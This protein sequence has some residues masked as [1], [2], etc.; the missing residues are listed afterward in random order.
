MGRKMI[1][2]PAWALVLLLAGVARADLG[3]LVDRLPAHANAIVAVDVAPLLAARQAGGDVPRSPVPLPRVA[4]LQGLVLAAHVKTGTMEPAWE[5][6]VMRVA[7]KPSMGAV[8][9]ASGGFV[10]AVAGREAAWCANDTYCILLDDRTLGSV[11]PADR[12][13]AARWAS[14]STAGVTAGASER[15]Y[16]RAAA[17]LVKPGTPLVV[18]LDLKDAV[19]ETG[20][21]RALESGGAQWAAGLPVGEASARLLAGVRGVTV[22]VSNI[23]PDGAEGVLAVEFQGDAAPL[24]PAA[25]SLVV[26]LLSENG[27]SVPDLGEWQYAA[28]GRSLTGTGR[29]SPGGIERLVGFLDTPAVASPDATAGKANGGAEQAAASAGGAAA[30]SKAYYKSVSSVL[31]YFRPGTSLAESAAWLNRNARRIDQLPS[32]GVDPDLLL[33]GADVSARLREAAGILSAGQQRVRARSL[34]AQAPAAYA[35]GQR[36]A[37]RAAQTR[38]DVTNA[39]RQAEQAASEER[40]NAIQEAAK[41]LQAANE[42]RGKVRAAMA[43]KYGGGF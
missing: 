5:V 27:L 35:A 16:L 43:Q 2:R 23:G 32:D 40:A 8:A 25:K 19:S 26:G 13:F 15:E 20:V 33:Y 37:Q 6:A 31:D 21:R 29:L 17:S 1:R 7:Q 3:E 24:A 10:D 38:A 9:S 41:P 36:D 12:Q 18:A 30:A 42:A 28:E 39:K 4:G 34:S 11:F 14:P 22:R